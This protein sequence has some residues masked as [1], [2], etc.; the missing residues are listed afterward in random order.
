MM[1]W[2]RFL[3]G[4]SAAVGAAAAF[5]H[6]AGRDVQPLE[7]PLGGTEG[8][9]TWRG[10]RIAYTVRGSGPPLLLVHAIHAAA[11][12]Y[13]WSG[14][15]EPLARQ[16]TVYAIDLLGFGRSDRPAIR[17]TASLYVALL[18][19]FAKQVVR[20][21]CAIA[22]S[23]LSAAYAIDLAA[24]DPSRF[25]ALVLCG[26]SGLTRLADGS[27][28]ASGVARLAV[29]TPVFGS[30]VFNGIVSR[31]SLRHFLE[32]AYADKSR[33]TEGFVDIHYAAA[34]QPGARHAPA[35]FISRQLD[36]DV[37]PALR[38]LAQPGLLVWG[39]R[40]RL[41]PVE[42]ARAFLA[43]KRDFELAVLSPAGDVPHDERSV[44]FT[45]VALDFLDRAA[46]TERQTAA[47]TPAR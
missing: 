6:L 4:G 34:H 7:N 15:I 17:Y 36:L 44:E 37:R 18:S 21:P 46:G 38:R 10:H 39:D 19:E 9:Y 2:R 12:S 14:A 16:R 24:R 28:P 11:W 41:T 43:A 40:A 42:E 5:N 35:A 3:L 1:Q 29:E 13:E 47:A 25:P 27:T 31:R 32:L 23:S 20:R 33:V 8:W 30:A 45:A 22:A 26:P